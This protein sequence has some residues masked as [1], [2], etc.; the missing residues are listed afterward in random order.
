MTTTPDTNHISA[1][2]V[3]ADTEAPIYGTLLK[4]QNSDDLGIADCDTGVW[5]VLPAGTRV[6]VLALEMG[7][8]LI[9]SDHSNFA[10]AGPRYIEAADVRVDEP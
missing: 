7:L 6:Q 4:G 5:E 3:R 2:E 10:G 9:D 1:S 8:A